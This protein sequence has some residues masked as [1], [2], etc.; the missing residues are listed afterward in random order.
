MKTKQK[1]SYKLPH[2][3]P[4]QI[5]QARIK[6]AEDLARSLDEKCQDLI[7]PVYVYRTIMQDL[8]RTL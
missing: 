3:T 1:Q 8:R 6:H 7:F 4:Q 2:Q 5:R